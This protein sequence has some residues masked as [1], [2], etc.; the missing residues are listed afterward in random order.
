MNHDNISRGEFLRTMGLGAAT[1]LAA[2]SCTT[3]PGATARRPNFVIVFADDFVYRAIGYNNPVV[4]T[5]NLDALAKGGII[6]DNAYVASPICVASRASIMSGMFPQQH[7]SVGL[8]AKSFQKVIVED[9]QYPTFAQL[10][11]E[12]GYRTAYCGK[13]HL[14]P[15]STFGFTE[16]QEH[17]DQID[18]ASFA[19]AAQFLEQR[20]GDDTPFLLWVS[21]HQPHVPLLAAQEWLD[22]YK[23]SDIK[24]DPNFRESPPE[25][26][27]Y[28]QGKPGERYYRDSQHVKNYKDL[29]AGPPRTEAQIVDFTLAYYAAISHL[30]AQVGAL[31]D[32]LKAS[33]QYD[34]TYFIFFADNGYHLGN[35]G[36]GNKITMHEEAVRVPMFVHSPRLKKTGERSGALVS[37]L[38]I[39]PTL[40][41]LAGIKVPEHA[42]GESLKPVLR[43]SRA[44]VRE[45]VASECVGV[46]GK[47]GE[48][49]RMVRTDRWKY[50]LTDSNEEALFDQQKDPYELTNVVT[51]PKN[52]ATVAKLRACMREWMAATGDTHAPL[53]E[54]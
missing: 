9:R 43:N 38:D 8:D 19:Y 22:L 35:H 26:S 34:D 54:T 50:V 5:P 6:L 17:G 37:S 16:G 23:D 24:V 33:G 13:S 51:D 25:G 12:N 18:N 28:N 29:P 41:D 10:L 46:G 47:V 40:L 14:G 11:A 53:P 44:T 15:P 52:A 1:A 4:K 31:I 32:Q 21:P 48:G 27:I 30:D 42:M 20:K 3:T 49:H 2:P 39:Y 7:G 36:L 45:Y